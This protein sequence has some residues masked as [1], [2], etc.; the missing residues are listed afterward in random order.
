MEIP[1]HAADDLDDAT[2]TALHAAMAVQR[3][4]VVQHLARAVARGGLFAAGEHQARRTVEAVL[5]RIIELLLATPF[6]AQPG[7]DIGKTLGAIAYG[8]ADALADTQARLLALLN[9]TPPQQA[10]VLYIRLITLSSRTQ[11]A[12]CVALAPR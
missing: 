9:Q 12:F 7:E 11:Q 6:D 2:R 10:T 3:P 8:N 5:D 1:L 4:M